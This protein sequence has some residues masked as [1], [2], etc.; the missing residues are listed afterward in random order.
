LEKLR[1]AKALS[2]QLDYNRFIPEDKF[3]TVEELDTSYID[4]ELADDLEDVKD[5]TAEREEALSKLASESQSIA[6]VCN[7]AT[8]KVK[9][10]YAEKLDTLSKHHQKLQSIIDERLKDYKPFPMVQNKSIV[11]SHDYTLGRVYETIDVKRTLP[12]LNIVF[13][14]S[15]YTSAIDMMKLY[16]A[17]ALLS[18]RVKQLTVEIYDPKNMCKDFSEFFTSDTAPY[19]KPNNMKLEEL[20]DTYRK[21]SQDNVI[22]LD[23]KTI[24]EYNIEAEAQEMTPKDY[25]LLLIIS[26]FEKQLDGDNAAVFKEYFKFSANT[27][28]MIWLLSSK[29]YANSL[30]V[31]CS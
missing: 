7:E 29:K 15:N 11:M 17:N 18:V 4:E 9:R 22:K 19:I 20:I 5:Y 2:V 3:K 21:Y 28:V 27:G 23:N 12:C 26:D 10:A 13:D 25:K 8:V 31:D 30:W 6:H 14:A 16:F 24:D 1:I